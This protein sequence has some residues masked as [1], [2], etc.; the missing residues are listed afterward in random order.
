MN[1][2]QWAVVILGVLILVAI[3]IFTPRYK[4]TAIGGDNYIITEQ[5][6]SLYARSQ[7]AIRLHWDKISLY[8]GATVVACGILIGLLRTR[9]TKNG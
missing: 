7:G 4:M 2:K 1:K 3:F 5:S 8:A 9:G 6:S